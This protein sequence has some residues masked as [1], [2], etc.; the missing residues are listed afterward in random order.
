MIFQ[1]NSGYKIF[2]K[3]ITLQIPVSLR[4]FDNCSHHFL[5]VAVDRSTHLKQLNNLVENIAFVFVV[6]EMLVECFCKNG[7]QLTFVLCLFQM[8]KDCDKV[9]DDVL[10]EDDVFGM[11]IVNDVRPLLC[12]RRFGWVQ[13][14][15]QQVKLS[16]NLLCHQF[17]LP[18][19]IFCLLD[20]YKPQSFIKLFPGDSDIDVDNPNHI[21]EMFQPFIFEPVA[22][23]DL[24]TFFKLSHHHYL[25][26]FELFHLLSC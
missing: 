24:H 3:E 6:M 15:N 25:N 20:K 2:F 12:G 18:E 19:N 4:I 23:D 11:K 14:N 13:K 1:G 26:E 7:N 21:H 10:V 16:Q 8:L 17:I 22:K 5:K 9:G